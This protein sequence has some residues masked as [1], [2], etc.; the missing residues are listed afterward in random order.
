MEEIPNNHLGNVVQTLPILVIN[1]PPYFHFLNSGDDHGIHSL[2][3]ELRK[4]QR[5]SVL[6][7]QAPTTFS[8]A[9]GSKKMS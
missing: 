1:Y 7:F 9:E 6:A 4:V 8:N 5:A 3:P 2:S